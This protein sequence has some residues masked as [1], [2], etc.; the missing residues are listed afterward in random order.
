M[1]AR[2]LVLKGFRLFRIR[3]TLQ[4]SNPSGAPY[5]NIKDVEAFSY[6]LIELSDI[7][8]PVSVGTA[9]YFPNEF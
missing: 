9:P 6:V 1:A 7:P 3:A 8:P 2:L 4:E 5:V